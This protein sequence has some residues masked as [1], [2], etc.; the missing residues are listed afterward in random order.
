MNLSAL[1]RDV[2]Q[3]HP[4]F[5]KGRG[6][7]HVRLIPLQAGMRLAKDECIYTLH[8]AGKTVLDVINPGE[9]GSMSSEFLT[10]KVKDI[11]EE[12][13]S[14]VFGLGKIDSGSNFEKTFYDDL[15]SENGHYATFLQT[16]IEGFK[17]GEVVDSYTKKVIRPFDLSPKDIGNV[18]ADIT[19]KSEYGNVY[20]SLKNGKGSIMVGHGITDSFEEREYDIN[21]KKGHVLDLVLEEMGVNIDKMVE[22]FNNYKS[23]IPSMFNRQ[24][25]VQIKCIDNL[26]DLLGA[27]HGYGYYIV[28]K[29]GLTCSVIDI[30][31]LEKL[32]NYIGNILSAELYYPYYLSNTKKN[33]SMTIRVTTDK[34]VFQFVIRN[35][36]GDIAPNTLELVK[37]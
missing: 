25:F 10:Y 26:K 36:N 12:T 7:G 15:R 20:L 18:V 33:K 11:N 8:Q 3:V 17:I 21:Y 2:I 28:R 13:A 37:L 1:A 9:P 34:H 24:E 29:L 35:K 31:T 27:A 32:N 30:T 5:K 23:Q 6:T 22:G 16:S 4:G 14:V 19:V